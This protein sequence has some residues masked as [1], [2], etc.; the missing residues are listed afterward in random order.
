[1]DAPEGVEGV[2]RGEL[3]ELLAGLVREAE[4]VGYH[5]A[6]DE[7]D[8]GT[9][10]NCCDD[11]AERHVTRCEEIQAQILDSFDVLRSDV[12]KLEQALDRAVGKE[13]P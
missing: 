10:E 5:R 7:A 9:D 13:G 12:W 2:T 11:G 1:M 3:E 8:L 6:V 4:C